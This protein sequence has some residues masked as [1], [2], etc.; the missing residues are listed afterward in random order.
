MNLPIVHIR[1]ASAGARTLENAVNTDEFTGLRIGDE[2]QKAL[3]RL[4]PHFS[5]VTTIIVD[6]RTIDALHPPSVAGWKRWA[7][8]ELDKWARSRLPPG[9]YEEQRGL[10]ADA[11]GAVIRDDEGWISPGE[12]SEKTGLDE[13]ELK[14]KIR[15]LRRR[16]TVALACCFQTQSA[17]AVLKDALEAAD[18][19]ALGRVA[20]ALDHERISERARKLARIRTSQWNLWTEQMC[21]MKLAA[22][23]WLHEQSHAARGANG[24]GEL[25]EVSAQL[26]AYRA[27]T[28]G[29]GTW[30]SDT[31]FSEL[32]ERGMPVIPSAGEFMRRLSRTQ[33]P[34]YGAIFKGL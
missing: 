16:G 5:P 15:Q 13:D 25:E 8:S 18:L 32:V 4:H 3:G 6:S 1:P 2:L 12:L 22:A 17:A 31:V 10:I 21:L 30:S 29:S 27:C 19:H 28:E 11:W 9:R 26:D 7:I 14:R 20:V 23:I 24:D 34:M 33:P